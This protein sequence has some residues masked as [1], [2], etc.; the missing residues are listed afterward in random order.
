MSKLGLWWD[1]FVESRK[2]MSLKFTDEL[3]VMTMKN[4]EKIEDKLTHC[5][6]TG[7]NNLTNFDP[8]TKK[9]K[10]YEFEIY[11]VVTCRDN[12]E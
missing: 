6:K 7:M 8:R 10:M 1:P 12:E 3:Y 2:C 9:S 5:F 11:R 4:D